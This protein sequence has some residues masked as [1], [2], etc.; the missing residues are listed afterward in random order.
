[1]KKLLIIK[2]GT[3]CSSALHAFG[4]FEDWIKQG[5]SQCR[6]PVI[7]VDAVAGAPLPKP[8][9]CFGVLIT[10]SHAMVTENLPWSRAIETWIPDL[11]ESGIP[12]L[13]ICYGHQLL[14]RALGGRVGYNPLGREVGTV[15]VLLKP[16]AGE[17]PL[18]RKI[19]PVFQAHTI[20]EQSVL[21]LPP[22]AVCLA[23]NAHERNHAFRIGECAWGVQFHPE[24][25]LQ[26]MREYIRK[27][28]CCVADCNELLR[29]VSET[30]E[31]G[32]ILQDFARIAELFDDR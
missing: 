10:G 8:E 25:T 27:E 14:A 6:L 19:N 28:V 21:E 4:D 7:V 16:A 3:T 22:G 5:I 20:H 1:V 2:A 32:K 29:A 13:G 12:L 17:D 9:A 31:S 30:P 24:Y 26:I 11:V 18:F 15:Q 23:G